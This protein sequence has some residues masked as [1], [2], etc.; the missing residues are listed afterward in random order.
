MQVKKKDAQKVFSKLQVSERRSTHHVAG[1]VEVDGVLTIPVYY[2]HGRGD[3]PG[4]VGDKFRKSLF[5][6]E[7]E[8]R[9]LVGCT[10]PRDGWQALVRERL[11]SR[12]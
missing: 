9:Q 5:V 1:V 7:D 6:S 12:S 8:F 3:M 11:P 4:R 10:M 2:S